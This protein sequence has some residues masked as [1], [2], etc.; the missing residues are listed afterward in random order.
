MTGPPPG[1]D[2]GRPPGADSDADGSWVYALT[3]RGLGYTPASHP[4]TIARARKILG[5]G[6][7]EWSVELGHQM[8]TRIIQEIPALGVGEDAF[9]ILRP[10]P[11]SAVLQSLMLVVLNDPALSGATPE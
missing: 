3:G 10:G 7:V 11:E 5:P 2:R 1:P 9:E 4:E 6:P 8:S